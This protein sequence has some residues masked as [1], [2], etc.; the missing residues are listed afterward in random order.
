MEPWICPRCGIVW[1]GWVAQCTCRAPTIVTSGTASDTYICP[2]D[3]LVFDT[4]GLRCS[5]CGKIFPKYENFVTCSDE[6]AS[7]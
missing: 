1:A 5:S 7:G 2:H 4:L 3:S 6:V